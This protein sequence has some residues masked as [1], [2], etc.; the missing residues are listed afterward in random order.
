MQQP[1]GHINRGALQALQLGSGQKG[2]D[3]GTWHKVS[4]K[5]TIFNAKEGSIEK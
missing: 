4:G 1:A 5:R 3:K 2:L